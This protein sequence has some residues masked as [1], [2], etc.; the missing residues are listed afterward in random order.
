MLLTAWELD[1]WMRQGQLKV[2]PLLEPIQPASIDLRLGDTRLDS[3]IYERVAR[4]HR[5]SRGVYPPVPST[6]V[7]ETVS[8]LERGQF[9]LSLPWSG[10]R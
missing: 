2:E 7:F 10:S 4:N 9:L 3:P 5:P 1:M 8:Y 6:R